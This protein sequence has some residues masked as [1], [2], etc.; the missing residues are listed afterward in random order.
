MGEV[1]L[2]FRN[3]FL[4]LLGVYYIPNFYR[5][6]ISVSR[7]Y[8]QGFIISN[9]Y[10][11]MNVYKNG[12]LICSADLVNGLYVLK[13]NEHVNYNTELFKIAKPISNKM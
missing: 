6:I 1:H 11:E 2:A 13:V 10:H 8:E 4:V 3:K 9:K 5:N 7:L 12:I